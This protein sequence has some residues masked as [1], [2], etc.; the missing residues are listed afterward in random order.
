[1]TITFAFFYIHRK[2]Y[3]FVKI[4]DFLFLMDLPVLRCPD[5][6]LSSSGKCLSVYVSVY[7]WQKICGRRSSRAN[8][9]NFMKL[10]I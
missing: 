3:W 2:K 10:Y 8:A 6:D 9:Q 1:M 7:V 4:F 5:N